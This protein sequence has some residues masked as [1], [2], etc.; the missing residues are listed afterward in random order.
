MRASIIV[1]TIT[2]A[3]MVGYVMFWVKPAPMSPCWVY[4]W[5]I[6]YK[7]PETNKVLAPDCSQETWESLDICLW[8]QRM[9]L[10][11]NK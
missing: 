9:I 1:L 2:V 4:V 11:F 7:C 3:I 6:M 8:D 5:D 10:E